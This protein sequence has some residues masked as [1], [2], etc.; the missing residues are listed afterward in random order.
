MITFENIVKTYR[1]GET[2]V[3]ALRGVSCHVETG[4]M[5]AIIG[6]S[7]CGKSTM[8]HIMGCLDTPTS[9][10]Y[11]LDGAEVSK[12]TD[13]QLAEVRNKKIGF[14]FQSF[15][16][17]ARTSAVANVELPLIYGNSNNR[18]IKALAALERVGLAQ[19]AFHMSNQLSGGEQQRVAIA[20]ALVNK[21]PIILADEPT[22]NLDSKSSNEI[23]TILENLNRDDGITIVM[24]THEAEI[25]KRASCTI[26]MR[27]GQIVS[28]FTL[29]GKGKANL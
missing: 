1:M 3:Q 9:G 7:G 24:V 23:M 5:V 22:G 12:L 14:I 17:L 28:D 26:A 25:A 11:F 20:R 16:L 18:R 21:P 27:D 29:S 19:R 15:N 13:S 10:K 4:E 2:T 6:P 8:M